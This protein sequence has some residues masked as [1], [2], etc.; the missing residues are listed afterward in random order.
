MLSM[1]PSFTHEDERLL[2]TIRTAI[3]EH[4]KGTWEDTMSIYNCLVPSC[5]Q[6]ALP[7]LMTRYRIIKQQVEHISENME[8]TKLRAEVE[9]LLAE[10]VSTCESRSG[11]PKASP[12]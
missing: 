1:E 6:Q 2:V 12:N 9:G 3:S 5:V 10:A 11:N 4:G 7:S 8:G